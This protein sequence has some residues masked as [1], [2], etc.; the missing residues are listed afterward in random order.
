MPLH[1]TKHERFSHADRNDLALVALEYCRAIGERSGVDRC[2]FYWIDPNEIAI[3]VD[4]E[5]GAWGASAEHGPTAREAQA[6]CALADLARRTVSETRGDAL[7]GQE[8]FDL[9][10]S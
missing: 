10:Q 4:A 2:R 3:T 1:I 6:V 9:A 5:L 8:T 7:A